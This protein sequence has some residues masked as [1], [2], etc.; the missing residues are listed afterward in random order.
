M[1]TLYHFTLYSARTVATET[2]I[3]FCNILEY[4]QNN[5][6]FLADITKVAINLIELDLDIALCSYDSN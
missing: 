5:N 4:I 2:G 3:N 1:F 6:T